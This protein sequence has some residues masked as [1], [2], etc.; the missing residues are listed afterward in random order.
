[1]DMPSTN[2]MLGRAV[3]DRWADLP[4]DVQEMLFS[5]AVAHAPDATERLAIELHERHPR[6]AHPAAPNNFA[7]K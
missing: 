1:M 6:T 5:A 2:E 3:F 4:R 7:A